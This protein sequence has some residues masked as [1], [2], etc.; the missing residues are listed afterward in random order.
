MQA[1]DFLTIS[2]PCS[3]YQIVLI[4]RVRA[5]LVLVGMT[6]DHLFLLSRAPRPVCVPL[7]C[8]AGGDP[9]T[10]RTRKV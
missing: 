2:N 8:T 10:G 9:S 3:D 4:R 5:T 6:N 7:N 1:E